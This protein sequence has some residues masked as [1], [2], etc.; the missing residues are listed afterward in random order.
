MKEKLEQKQLERRSQV[1]R[2]TM[3]DDIKNKLKNA[4]GLKKRDLD[5]RL[6]Q[7]E[8]ADEKQAEKLYK[9]CMSDGIIGE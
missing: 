2:D 7:L 1:S 8:E 6:K 9:A 3:M 4:N 5:K